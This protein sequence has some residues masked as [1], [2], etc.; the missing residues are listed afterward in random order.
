[1]EELEELVQVL[2]KDLRRFRGWWLTEYLSLRALLQL[3]PD[4][5]DVGH[6]MSSAEARFQVYSAPL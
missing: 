4:K 5:A 6:L 2:S 1:V 3:V